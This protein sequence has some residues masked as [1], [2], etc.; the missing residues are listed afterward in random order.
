MVQQDGVAK[1]V[2]FDTV[3]DLLTYVKEVAQ[4]TTG[5]GDGGTNIITM[6]LSNGS[7]VDFSIKNVV[8]PPEKVRSFY[9]HGEIDG[10]LIF[11]DD[12]ITEIKKPQEVSIKTHSQGNL[13]VA[14]SSEFVNNNMLFEVK[15]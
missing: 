4:T 15:L 6:T 14:P 12:K 5:S 7:T 9:L 2:S 3:D 11:R 10:I 8:S 1:Q 13:N